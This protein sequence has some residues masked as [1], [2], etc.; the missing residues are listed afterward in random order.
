MVRKTGDGKRRAQTSTQ[1]ET[2]VLLKKKLAEGQLQKDKTSIRWQEKHEVV[3]SMN[4][5]LFQYNTSLT[6]LGELIL[7]MKIL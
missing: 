4:S 5:E 6:N 3:R 1:T 2:R 7:T